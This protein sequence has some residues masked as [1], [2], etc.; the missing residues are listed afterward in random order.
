MLAV[1]YW[2][3]SY[4]K[5]FKKRN[6]DQQQSQILGHKSSHWS[7]SIYRMNDN[8]TFKN[9]NK[10]RVWRLSHITRHTL[11]YWWISRIGIAKFF[12]GGELLRT[13]DQFWWGLRQPF[14]NSYPS[15]WHQ[16]LRLRTGQRKTG[17]LTVVVLRSACSVS[18][19]CQWVWLCMVLSHLLS[20]SCQH[21]AYLQIHSTG[22]M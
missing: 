13:S 21:D 1:I 20:L 6:W 19:Q 2:S 22:A 3:F 9:L 5:Q 15:Q 8:F 4:I 7:P 17:W 12:N 18:P 14:F 11:D 10:V 16:K